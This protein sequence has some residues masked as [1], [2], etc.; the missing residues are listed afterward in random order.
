MFASIHVC[1][2]PA[3]STCGGSKRALNPL[4]LD[5]GVL[6]CHA[7]SG[8]PTWV[9]WKNNSALNHWAVSSA[10]CTSLVSP[11]CYNSIHKVSTS[12]LSFS[13]SCLSNPSIWETSS[14]DAPVEENELPLAPDLSRM[15]LVEYHVGDNWEHIEI[16]GCE[17]GPS[18][19]SGF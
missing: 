15:V 16:I 6:G 13:S 19:E 18:D 9:L 1:T 4:D 3:F 10:S 14:S 8:N 11:S 12:S 5:C 7:G 17:C 2:L